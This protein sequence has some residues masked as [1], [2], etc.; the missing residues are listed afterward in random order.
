MRVAAYVRVST[1]G[2]VK[3]QTIDQQLETIHR[4]AR[5]K[6]WELPEENVFRDDGYSGASL[7]RPALDALRD[8]ARFRELDAVVVLSPD[9]LARNC[10]HQM[11]LIEELE[12]CGCRAEFVERPMG[13]EPDDQLLLQ[14]RGAVSE[15][16]RTLI[17]ERMRRGKL[18]K[19]KAGSC[20][21]GRASLR[22][23]GSTPTGPAILTGCGWTRR[24][25][26][27]WR[28]SSRCTS[29]KGRASSGCPRGYGLGASAPLGAGRCGRCPP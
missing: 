25:R 10:V 24:K 14:I 27:W 28:R 23:T 18:A 9:R 2:Q 12:R 20:C 29:R 15:Y 19:L 6:G 1:P 22:A 26:P 11:V 7:D 21:L 5:D 4:Y 8:K 17:K 16:E 13:S 3:L